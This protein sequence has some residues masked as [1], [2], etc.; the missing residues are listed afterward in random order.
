MV[1]HQRDVGM[2]L[3]AEQVDAAQA[4]LAML[5]G[6]THEMLLAQ[7]AGLADQRKALELRMGADGCKQAQHLHGLRHMARDEAQML[8]IALVAGLEDERAVDLRRGLSR[9][10]R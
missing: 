10:F 7:R 6:I 2:L 8:H 4:D 9:R 1:H 3:P 5:A